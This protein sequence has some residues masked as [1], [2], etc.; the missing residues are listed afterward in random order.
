MHSVVRVSNFVKGDTQY[1]PRQ[2][3]FPAQASAGHAYT[4]VT[5]TPDVFPER[6]CERAL[7]SPM[8]LRLGSSKA[9]QPVFASTT[10]PPFAREREREEE[11]ERECV[12]YQH[13]PVYRENECNY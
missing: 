8:R 10:L 9:Y 5:R 13:F 6:L 4:R 11:K 7:E 12:C 3:L 2:V 1:L